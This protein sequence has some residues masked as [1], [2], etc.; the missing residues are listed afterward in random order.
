LADDRRAVELAAGD[1][2]VEPGDHRVELLRDLPVEAT[3]MAEESAQDL[4]EGEDHL[5]VGQAQ[6]KALVHVLA[7]QKGAFL[8]TGWAELEDL[9]AEESGVFGAAIGVGAVDA[10]H[11]LAAVAAVEKSLYSFV[12]ARQAGA[13]QAACVVRIVVG[14]KL[15]E[16]GAEQPLQ[17]GG[18]PLPVGTWRACRKLE[19]QRVG[20]I[21]D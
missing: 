13:T 20:H 11:A 9:A 2:V 21:P 5:K 1:G 4:G 7:E 19:G 8:E 16:M 14:R 17:K 12:D 15:R 10:R 3:V 18:A 6:Q